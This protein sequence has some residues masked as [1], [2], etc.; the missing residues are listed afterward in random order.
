[1]WNGSNRYSDH[2]AI[3]WAYGL[4]LIASCAIL[5]EPARSDPQTEKS[6][7]VYRATLPSLDPALL[8]IPLNPTWPKQL[9]VI[10]DSVLLG[11]KTTLT[12]SFSDW[13]VTVFGRPALMIPKA[14]ELLRQYSGVIGPV[15]VVAIGYNSLWE[16]DRKNFEHWAARFDKSVEDMLSILKRKGAQKIVWVML[17]ELTPD[18]LPNSRAAP[19]QYQEYA[20]YFPYVN[21]RLRA[22]I[23]HHPEMALADWAT[24]ARIPGITY[25]AIHVNTRGADLLVALL[26]VAIGIDVMPTIP[27]Q[28][29][30]KAIEGSA[31]RPLEHMNGISG[32]DPE[33]S[34]A[35]AT[36]DDEVTTVVLKPKDAFRD[37]P[38]CPEMIVVPAGTF[39]MGAPETELG[40]NDTDGPQRVVMIRHPFAIGKFEVTFAEWEACVADGGCQG[41]PSPLDEGWGRGR[42]PVINVSW[43]DAKQYVAWLSRTTH[44]PYRLPAEAEWEYAARAGTTSPFS[45]GSTIT[46]DQA[47]FQDHFNAANDDESRTHYRQQSIEVG[48]FPPNGWGIYDI[49]GNVW[50]WVEDSWHENYMEAPGSGLSWPDG[51][52]SYR[53]LR[54]G[55][56]YSLATDVRSAS[57]RREVPDYR[58][59]E[60]GFRIARTLDEY[61]N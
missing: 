7:N 27:G 8:G 57:R 4:L 61:G 49:H 18:L 6:P 20:W 41:N 38:R 59:A 16:K 29:A 48:S 50:E 22:I 15:V 46:T 17:R 51:D 58:S 45:T 34:R 40:Y 1:M 2:M 47:N 30:D 35:P 33:P 36:S 19:L 28:V 13:N 43:E 42:K 54:G 31:S 24:V 21:E 55:S 32:A 9:F 44:K 14:V 53:V 52:L 37:C 11:A 26:G 60:F 10:A 25:D 3:N 39:V 23:E 5:A 12:K 56:W